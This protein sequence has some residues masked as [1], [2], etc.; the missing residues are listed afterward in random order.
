MGTLVAA[1]SAQW[2]LF[3]PIHKVQ[4]DLSQHR[5]TPGPVPQAGRLHNLLLPRFEGCSQPQMQTAGLG[6]AGSWKP[7]WTFL[8]CGEG[9]ASP[10]TPESVR[11]PHIWIDCIQQAPSCWGRGGPRTVLGCSLQSAYGVGCI[12][13]VTSARNPQTLPNSRLLSK[14][15]GE[16]SPGAG[17][18]V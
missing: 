2:G 8:C 15:V 9:P 12:A 10:P 6:K 11:C 3:I 13:G 5:A 14:R 18:A 1:E 17:P 16:V 4:T 7:A